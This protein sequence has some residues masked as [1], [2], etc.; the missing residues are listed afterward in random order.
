MAVNSI[1][2]LR[3][4]AVDTKE[5]EKML[6]EKCKNMDLIYIDAQADKK[7]MDEKTLKSVEED[8][9]KLKIAP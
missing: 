8:L 1:L 4:K 7:K 9:A 3:Q 2:F 5:L 6:F